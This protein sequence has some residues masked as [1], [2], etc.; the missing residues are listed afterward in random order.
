MTTS[1]ERLHQL[2][3]ACIDDGVDSYF[4]AT[5]DESAPLYV[6]LRM[7]AANADLIAALAEIE[8]KTLED[9]PRAFISRMA[10]E[11]VGDAVEG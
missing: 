6:C 8:G 9:Y 3:R 2:Y 1:R 11:I 4:E 5:T 10:A 7:S